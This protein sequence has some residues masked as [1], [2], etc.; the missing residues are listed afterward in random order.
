MVKENQK[1]HKGTIELIE[2]SATLADLNVF[3]GD[4]LWVTDTEIYENRDIAGNGII[5]ISFRTY[6]RCI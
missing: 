1:L 6:H 2:E 4:S 5:C 3:P